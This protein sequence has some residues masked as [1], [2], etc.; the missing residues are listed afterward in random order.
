MTTGSDIGGFLATVPSFA[1]FGQTLDPALYAALPEGWVLGIADVVSST[2]AIASGSYKKVNMAGAAVIAAV[3]N[4]LGNEPYPFVFGGD[5]ASFA[6]PPH[7][8]PAARAALAS[9]ATFV[10]EVYGLELRIATV[11]VGAVRAAGLDVRIARFGASP[12][13]HYTMFAGGGL[14]W[15]ERQMKVGEFAIPPAPPG[16]RPDLTGLSCRFEAMP[17]QRGIIL[18][19]IVRPAHAGQ[20]A[21]ETPEYRKVIENIIRLVEASPDMARPIPDGGPPLA[22]PPSGLELEA[23][24]GTAGTL[25]GWLRWLLL[26]AH[27]GFSSLVLR[28]RIPIGSFNPDRYLN[29]LVANSDYRKYHD[30]LRM[31]IDCDPKLAD[32]I[33]GDLATAEAGGIVAYG[34][35]RQQAALMTCLTTSIYRSDHIHF[36]DGAS[37]GYSAASISL[38][39]KTEPARI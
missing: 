29:E 16:S 10:T 14:A 5:G 24:T 20:P 35:H 32:E 2:Q 33:E 22:W 11:P 34:L 23:L 8:V 17:A 31:T 6:V 3:S 39:Y 26:L 37:G 38:K 13:L 27:T 21:A 19:I 25:S 18:S 12:D 4:A 15:A 36:L 1:H 30:G 7:W 28:L 9:T